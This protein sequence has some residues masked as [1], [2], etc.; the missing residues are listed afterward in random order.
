MSSWEL[1]NEDEI[2][3]MTTLNY[4][5][6]VFNLNYPLLKEVDYKMPMEEQK[7]DAKGYDR[8][9]KFT[10]DIYGKTYFICSQWYDDLNRGYFN[11]WLESRT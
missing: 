10:V 2:E 1:D 8:Y 9:W 5:K 11:K 7:K 4:S 3:K 6:E